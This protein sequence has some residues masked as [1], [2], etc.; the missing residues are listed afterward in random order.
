[1]KHCLK[2][3]KL[4]L[5]HKNYKK[6]VDNDLFDNNIKP[7]PKEPNSNLAMVATGQK[8]Q[9]LRGS[10]RNMNSRPNWAT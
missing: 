9:P 4:K 6:D 2:K 7:V 5:S 8:S 3:K 10:G 1:M